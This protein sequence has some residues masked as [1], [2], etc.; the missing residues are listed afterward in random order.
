[1]YVLDRLWRGEIAP[2]ERSFRQGSQYQGTVKELCRQMDELLK[3][4]SPE[5]KE[6][7]EAVSALKSDISMMEHED[8]FIC[9]FRLGVGILLDAVSAYNGQFTDP[10]GAG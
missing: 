5:A 8:S 4:L 1:M 6:Q 9:G 3:L 7:L 10:N 2:T